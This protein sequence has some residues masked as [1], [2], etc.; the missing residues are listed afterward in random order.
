LFQ[1]LRLKV[2]ILELLSVCVETQPGLIE[3]F[4]DVQQPASVTEGAEASRVGLLLLFLRV[5]GDGGRPAIF[6]KPTRCSNC[7]AKS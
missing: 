2:A 1:D 4:F 7:A 5:G 6:C 3:I